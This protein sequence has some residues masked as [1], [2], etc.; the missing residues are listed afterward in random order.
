MNFARAKEI[1]SGL[2]TRSQ[3]TLIGGLVAVIA[4]FFFLYSFASKPSY[5]TL[6][7]NLTPSDTGSAEK[8]L[9]AAGVTYKT[10][11]GGT[12][13][14]VLASQ[15]SQ[16]RVALAEKG[17]LNGGHVGFEIFD[18]SKLGAT[19]FQQK[20]DYQRALEGEIARTIEQIQGV[21]SA[22]VQLVLPD[23]TLFADEQSKA[24]AAVLVAGGS[25]LDASTVRGIASLVASSVKGLDS[26]KVTITDETGALLWPTEGGAGS[27]SAHTKLEADSLYASQVASQINALLTSTLG[28]GKAIARVHADLNVDQTTVDKV[29]YGKKSIPLQQNLSQETLKSQ[30]GA[31]GALPAGTTTNTAANA[32]GSYAAGANGNGNSNYNH[33]TDQTTFGVDKTISRSVV[34]PGSVNK[35]D[36]ALVVD[37][38]IPAAQVTQLQKSVAS[39]AGITPARGD[40]IAVSRIAFA[41]QTT[42]TA[43]KESPVASI[44]ANPLGLAKKVLLG[45]GALIF[46][47]MMRRALKRREGEASVPEPTWLREIEGGMT[48]AEL[49]AAP[50][51]PALPSADVE[52]RDQAR[53]AVEEIANNK[54]E[55]IAHQVAA[56][57]KE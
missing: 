55:A 24:S 35:L 47:F 23:D 53:E 15:L 40:T 38:S 5:S 42:A 1:F 20:V 4:T 50:A 36:V 9:A 7:S 56:W 13:I 12:K 54:P 3:I 27:A 33:K 45:L 14:S 21:Q 32:A 52:R 43:T 57:M 22:D 46:L 6:A 11:S 19:D 26:G 37:Q 34:A 51:M 10:D 17:V 16:A 48:V 18:Q 44:M 8:A 41:K 39:L 2:E 31:T 28:P 25:T 49:E 29:T 30:G